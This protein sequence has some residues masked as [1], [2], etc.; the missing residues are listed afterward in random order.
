MSRPCWRRCGPDSR[1][2]DNGPDSDLGYP[3]S[4]ELGDNS[5]FTAYYQKQGP[6]EKRSLLWTRWSMGKVKDEQVLRQEVTSLSI[7]AI[8]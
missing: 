1:L 8:H 3:S 7:V 2:R 4:V 5:L 6:G